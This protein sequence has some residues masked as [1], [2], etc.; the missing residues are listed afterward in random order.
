[1]EN[2]ENLHAVFLFHS[3]G[4]FLSHSEI[5][6]LRRKLQKFW[7]MRKKLSII[8]ARCL[9][10]DRGKWIHDQYFDD[11][12]QE[13]YKPNGKLDKILRNYEISKK[14]NRTLLPFWD[15]WMIR[16]E[17]AP[18]GLT[19]LDEEFPKIESELK[20]L[21]LIEEERQQEEEMELIKRFVRLLAILF[22]GIFAVF[23]FF[24]NF[25]GFPSKYRPP[26]KTMPWTIRSSLVVLWGVCWMFYNSPPATETDQSKAIWAAEPPTVSLDD[27]FYDKYDPAQYQ[28]I[29]DA[30][31][32]P[33]DFPREDL[34]IV[35]QQPST[36]KISP[37]S[38]SS[39]AFLDSFDSF[40]EGQ[41]NQELIGTGILFAPQKPQSLQMMTMQHSVP[42]ADRILCRPNGYEPLIAPEE[43]AT[44]AIE[45]R[46]SNGLLQ[47]STAMAGSLW[48]VFSSVADLPTAQA[49]S[50][51]IAQNGAPPRTP[52]TISQPAHPHGNSTNQSDKPFKCKLSTCPHSTQGFRTKG[53]LARH[54]KSRH[55]ELLSRDAAARP[56]N[57]LY[58]CPDPSCN[59]ASKPFA[60]KDNRDNHVAKQHKSL[61]SGHSVIAQGISN[62]TT[63]AK[64]IWSSDE[65]KIVSPASPVLAAG[66]STG[67]RRRSEETASSPGNS[68][69]VNEVDKLRVENAQLKRRIRDLEQREE[70][71][72]FAIRN[73]KP[74]D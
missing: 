73:M 14:E 53:L 22:A 51:Q 36:S 11:G 34:G 50:D 68:G 30:L 1:M 38:G 47:S 23:L 2:F 71:L 40:Q 41:D 44:Y 10:C 39:D 42:A 29:L 54:T 6:K 52:T 37:I 16:R 4:Q 17:V 60:R 72:L 27:S 19:P 25:S 59:R 26:C 64:C 31:D 20:K 45:R 58:Y 74:S 35:H 70:T 5:Q 43:D 63:G 66:P 24:C 48:P 56:S 46:S 12:F 57:Q 33:F 15:W 65:G 18:W 67:K 7:D 28:S 49:T 21:R 69:S 13:Y 9:G 55:R 32:T 61:A 3:F 8:Q 62:I